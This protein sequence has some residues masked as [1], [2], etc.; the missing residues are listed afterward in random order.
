MSTLVKKFRSENTL[1]DL[2]IS[3]GNVLFNTDQKCNTCSTDDAEAIVSSLRCMN[4]QALA[5][6]PFDLAAGVEF[7]KKTNTS[8][9]VLLSSNIYS[10]TNNEAVFTT[11]KTFFLDGISVKVIGITDPSTQLDPGYYYRD[12]KVVLNEL[13]QDKI[14][15]EFIILLSS[16]PT[17]ENAEILNNY[18]RINLLLSSDQDHHYMGPTVYK[19]SLIA[20]SVNRGKYL[21]SLRIQVGNNDKWAV[22][23]QQRIEQLNNKIKILTEKLRRHR[24]L[25]QQS[26]HDHEL[27]QKTEYL[28]QQVQ[29][30]QK[31]LLQ[32]TAAQKAYLKKAHLF[33]YK[34]YKIDNLI[35]QDHEI[36]NILKHG[37]L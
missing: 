21:D 3:P 28:T 1:P 29:T 15:S 10:I 8:F 31:E 18:P 4:L 19:H 11:V 35:L 27:I 12:Y 7:L 22:S 25:L 30:C 33:E 9:P 2:F 16:L 6:G 26:A 23:H 37:Q 36:E 14:P 5:V 13:L 17:K 20:Q 24:E 34:Q 32:L